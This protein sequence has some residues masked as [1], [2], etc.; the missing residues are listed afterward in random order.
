MVAYNGTADELGGTLARDARARQGRRS[1]R[2]LAA[3]DERARAVR[4]R[5]TSEIGIVIDLMQDIPAPDVI[6]KAAGWSRAAR[7]RRL[8]R[9]RAAIPGGIWGGCWGAGARAAAQSERPSC[10]QNRYAADTS[11]YQL[12]PGDGSKKRWFASLTITEPM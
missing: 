7:R 9:L 5:Y 4:R 8:L 2:P 12:R 6:T 3:V 10:R 1:L 11:A